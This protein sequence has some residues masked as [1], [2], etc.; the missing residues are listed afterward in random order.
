MAA[1]AGRPA[2]PAKIDQVNIE[3]KAPRFFHEL[4]VAAG[5][6]A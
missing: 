6:L 5:M 4:R 3:A 1:G 2:V